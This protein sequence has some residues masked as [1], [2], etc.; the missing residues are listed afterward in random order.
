MLARLQRAV[1]LS[2]AV[3]AAVWA[4]A[5]VLA[6]LPLL[7]MIGAGAITFGYAVVLGVEFALM[8]AINRDDPA[9]PASASQLLRAWW[10]ESVLA[11]RVFGWRQ[12]FRANAVADWL[13]VSCNPS[14]RRAV[15]L[16]HGFVCNRAFWNPWMR[17]LRREDVPY[18]AVNLEPVFGSIDDYADIVEEAVQRST[19]ATGLAPVIVAHSMGGLA[20]RAWSARYSGEARVE[21]IVTIGTPHRGTWLG[22]FASTPNGRQM[23]LG[24]AWQGG[25]RSDGSTRYTCFYSHCDNIV[26]PCSN[27]TLPGADNRHLY[28]RAHVELA[29]QPEVID[30]ALRWASIDR[31]PS[32]GRA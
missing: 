22:R 19:A 11:V 3:A 7:A 15:L 20:V 8:R 23:R 12:P 17:R 24:A 28:G 4:I 26:F 5:F 29:F 1:V 16:V 6:G 9:P 32:A 2:L 27:A 30:E 21:R 18:L 25:L 31:A 10:S 14:P 13:P